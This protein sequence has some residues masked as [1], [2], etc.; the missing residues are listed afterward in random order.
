[1]SDIG[2]IFNIYLLNESMNILLEKKL[3][4]K[5]KFHITQQHWQVICLHMEKF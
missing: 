3:E 1:M 2:S 4:I 5:K